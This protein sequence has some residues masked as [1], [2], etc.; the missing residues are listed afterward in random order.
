MSHASYLKFY[1]MPKMDN[2]QFTY[3][4]NRHTEDGINTLIYSVFHHH[5][6]RDTYARLLF[7]GY[8]SAFN[9]ILLDSLNE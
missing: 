8:S 9:T 2:V 3:L 6:K 5:D 4:T 1:V 7:I